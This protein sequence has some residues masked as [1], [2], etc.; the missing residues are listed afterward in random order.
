MKKNRFT[1]TILI[2]ALSVSFSVNQSS[3]VNPQNG[4]IVNARTEAD[5]VQS[6]L[7]RFVAFLNEN[8]KE[9]NV[10][11]RAGTGAFD[12]WLSRRNQIA[13][14]QGQSNG[15]TLRGML[16]PKK[17]GEVRIIQPSEGATKIGSGN[18]IL[19]SYVAILPLQNANFH[20]V[21]LFFRIEAI[22]QVKPEEFDIA[23]LPGLL[24][25]GEPKATR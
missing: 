20:F 13:Q 18:G 7:G 3:A 2:S 24:F 16:I 4:I 25:F 5:A 11:E 22:N 15:E 12:S 10:V 9:D 17:A 8:L 14:D 23:F 1:L 21:A 19:G 6:A